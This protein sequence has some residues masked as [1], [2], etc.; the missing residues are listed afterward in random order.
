M[1]S[2]KQHIMLITVSLI[3]FQILKYSNAPVLVGH[4]F[5]FKI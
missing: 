5:D 2:L 3:M 4:W 1:K